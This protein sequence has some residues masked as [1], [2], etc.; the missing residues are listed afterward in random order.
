M[1]TEVIFSMKRACREDYQIKGYRFGRGGQKAACI[2]GP[3][4]GTEIQQ[5]YIC[6]QL[7]RMLKEIE[8]RG[9]IAGDNEILVIPSLNQPS[10]NVNRH[11]WPTDNSD[12]NRMFPGDQKGETT[13]RLAGTLFEKVRGYSYGIQFSSL[14]SVGEFVPHVRML[15][16]GYHSPS[17]ANLFG[18]PYVMI[19]RTSAYDTASLNY[20]WQLEGTSA[21]SVYTAATENIDQEAAIQSASSVLRFLTRMGIIRHNSHSGYIASV[22]TEEDLANVITS[23]PGFFI[24]EKNPGTEVSC[25]DVM[26]TIIDPG[27][28][29]IVSQV[30]APTDGI[31]FYAHTKP[32]VFEGEVLFKIIRR[33]HA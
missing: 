7:V 3:M 16:T 20:N 11:F 30:L 9:G 28:G 15:E 21:F 29:E 19:Q 22:I 14:Y 26:A 13:K 25:G 12:V 10:V 33:L 27:T 1:R 4:R 2:V 23:A 6:S 17:L 8:S 18:L 31:V 24:R 32:L 5:L